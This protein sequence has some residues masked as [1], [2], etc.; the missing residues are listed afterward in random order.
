MYHG[1]DRGAWYDTLVNFL[2]RN[3]KLFLR[4]VVV[5]V[6]FAA[7]VWGAVSISEN[8]SVQEIVA[9]FGY[10]GLLAFAFVS[11]FNVIVPIPL[12]SF[13]P[14]FLASGLAFWPTVLTMTVG[15]TLGDVLGFFIGDTGRKLADPAMGES[16][17]LRAI[18]RFQNTHPLAPYVLLFLYA[19]LAPTPNELVVIPLSFAGF[20]LRYMLPVM[21]LGNGVFNTL[22]SL[23]VR[24]VVGL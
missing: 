12:V 15:M 11:G 7:A 2:R 13:V 19:S 8:A 14:V 4:L 5:L 21:L 24:A 10:G 22:A 16:K 20:K 6:L 9:R 17:M 23:G 1:E 3:K 18:A